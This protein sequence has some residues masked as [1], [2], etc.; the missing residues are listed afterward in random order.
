MCATSG[1][2]SGPI[3]TGDVVGLAARCSS[4]HVV[5]SGHDVLVDGKRALS[6][7]VSSHTCPF[8]MFVIVHVNWCGGDTKADPFV[9]VPAQPVCCGFVHTPGVTPGARA[10]L[11][12]S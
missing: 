9:V 7:I 2:T 3:S 11:I 12:T 10:P 4:C 1:P 6:G 8:G 5:V